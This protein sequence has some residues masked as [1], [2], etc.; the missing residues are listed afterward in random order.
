MK[1]GTIIDDKEHTIRGVAIRLPCTDQPTGAAVS[2]P[3]SPSPPLVRTYR[4]LHFVE[5]NFPIPVSIHTLYHPHQFSSRLAP[6][7]EGGEQEKVE[8][9]GGGEKERDGQRI[10][11][12]RIN[13]RD[14]GRENAT[15]TTP[16]CTLPT[17]HH[18]WTYLK[19]EPVRLL[20]R[21]P[22]TVAVAVTVAAT[23]TATATANSNA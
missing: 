22:V 6:T 18:K 14:E 19:K 4:P 21:T 2:L 8:R 1:G 16:S 9:E 5:G 12:D 23:A 3:A 10:V 15:P 7:L 17:N 11:R 13:E 20:Q